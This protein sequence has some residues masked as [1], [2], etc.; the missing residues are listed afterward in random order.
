MSVNERRAS[1]MSAPRPRVASNRVAD[2]EKPG[3]RSAT[4]PLQSENIDHRG[5]TSSQKTR[6]SRDQQPIVSD[7]RTERM[8]MHTRDKSQVRTRNPVKESSSAG[9]RGEFMERSRSKRGPSQ[10][11]GASPNSRKKDKQPV[12]SQFHFLE[13]LTGL[14]M[15]AR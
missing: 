14:E 3:L 10:P 5:S 13:L 1:Y 8:A 7:K 11:E 12:E 6:S 9:N 4:S 2:A 15:F